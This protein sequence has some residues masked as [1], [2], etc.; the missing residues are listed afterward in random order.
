MNLSVAL[1]PSPDLDSRI[2]VL[3]CGN[4]VDTFA[5][6]T[7]RFL[8]LIDTMPSR[9][10]M[11][12]GMRLLQDAEAPGRSIV[13]INTHGDWD[14]VCGNGAFA[15]PDAEYPAPVIGSSHTAEIVLSEGTSARL[16]ALRRE[17]PGRL[18]TAEQWA[19]TVRHDGRLT[20]DCGDLILHLL[21]TPGHRPDHT[22]I[23]CP[24]LRLLFAGDAAEYPLPLVADPEGLP[25]LRESLHRMDALA[26]ETV[27]YCHAVGRTDPSVIRENIA[28]FDELEQ[29]VRI[30]LDGGGTLAEGADAADALRWRLE[31]AIGPEE[32]AALD[33]ET[34]A[35]YRRSHDLAIRATVRQTT[36]V[37]A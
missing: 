33:A 21:P 27:L 28:Y 17:N 11:L 15:A 25:A 2:R 29:R 9:A 19:P 1:L 4:V 18:D 35:F 31:D 3:R 10:A 32:T 37:R 7:E 24:E 6:V 20:V 16:V 5:L 14:H 22:A 8:V 26:P 13:A 34:S 36:A 30:Y 12:A 23:W